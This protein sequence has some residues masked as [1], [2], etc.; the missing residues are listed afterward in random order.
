[1]GFIQKREKN[2]SDEVSM[3]KI[4]VDTRK[5]NYNAKIRFVVWNDC[6]A[7]TNTKPFYSW[8]LNFLRDKK[9]IIRSIDFEWTVGIIKDN[10]V[11]YSYIAKHFF[12]IFPIGGNYIYIDENKAKMIL[13]SIK[14]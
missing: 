14:L 1:M 13:E 6:Y 10:K 5:Q 4:L 2:K 11:V 8:S 7:D 9:P 12:D 3:V